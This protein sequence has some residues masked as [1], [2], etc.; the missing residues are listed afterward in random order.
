MVKKEFK[1]VGIK[2]EESSPTLV[3]K[4]QYWLNNL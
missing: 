2:K 3:V 1:V 4:F